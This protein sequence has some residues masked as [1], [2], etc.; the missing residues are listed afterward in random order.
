MRKNRKETRKAVK[1]GEKMLK[2]NPKYEGIES[3]TEF[4]GMRETIEL[5]VE[6]DKLSM[7]RRNRDR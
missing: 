3:E 4:T 7:N 1:K 2:K 5:V 6:M